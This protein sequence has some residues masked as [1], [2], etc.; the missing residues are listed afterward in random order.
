MC[1]SPGLCVNHIT[2]LL[3]GNTGHCGDLIPDSAGGI[4]NAT[5]LAGEVLKKK[6]EYVSQFVACFVYMCVCVCV[7]VCQALFFCT[8]SW[9]RQEE[10]PRATA[11]CLFHNDKSAK[12]KFVYSKPGEMCDANKF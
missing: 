10:R 7:C 12:T 6:I 2:A 3:S 1:A 5:V 9:L 8:C 4:S 11:N